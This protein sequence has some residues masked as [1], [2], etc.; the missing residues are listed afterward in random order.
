MSDGP[1]AQQIEYWNSEASAKWTENHAELDARIGPLGRLALDRA[2]P[3]PG[4]RVLDVG[5]GCGATSL[6]LALRV[7]EGGAVLGVDVS[8]PMLALARR[9]AD[10]AGAKSLRFERAD[11]QTFAF[12]LG[13][14]DVAVSRFGVMFFSDPV[15]AFANLRRALRPGGRLAFVCWRA[16]PENPWAGLPFQAVASVVGPPPPPEP[17]APGPFALAD[18]ERLRAILD[19]AGFAESALDARDTEIDLAGGQGLEA[20]CRFAVFVGPAS[21]LL[22]EAPAEQRARAAEAVRAALAPHAQGPRVPLGAA[23]W[24]VSATNPG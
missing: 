12:E 10:E 11:A 20:A 24:L 19:G 22:G 9:R 15:A 18:P 2:A 16:L 23:V 14:F 8:E 6:E 3:A 21:R 4:E 17:G 13:A 7:G 5:C 1:N